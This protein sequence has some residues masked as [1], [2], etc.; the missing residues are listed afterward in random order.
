[1]NLLNS[2]HMTSTVW[3]NVYNIQDLTLFTSYHKEY[4]KIFKFSV[5]NPMN[6]TTV[7]E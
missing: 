4:S 5:L 7:A 3:S 1:M 6:Y 2:V